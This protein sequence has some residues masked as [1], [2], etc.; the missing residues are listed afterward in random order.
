[1]YGVRLRELFTGGMTWRE[2]GVYLRGLPPDS[3][4][5]TA[6]SDGVPEPT[7]EAALLADVIDAVQWVRWQIAAHGVE[8]ESQ[9]PKQPRPYPRWWDPERGR[10]KNSPERVARIEDARRRAAERKRKIATGQIA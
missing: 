8:K 2:L 3:A 10:K 7:P 1:V 4:T 6:M 9:L 5:R